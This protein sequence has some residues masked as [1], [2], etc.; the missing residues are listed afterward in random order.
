[1]E[2]VASVVAVNA[3]VNIVK[4]RDAKAV[5]KTAKYATKAVVQ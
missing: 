2:E 5:P 1:V 3:W 4:E